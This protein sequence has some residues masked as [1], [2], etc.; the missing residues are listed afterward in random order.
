MNLTVSMISM[1]EEKAVGKVIDS[2]QAVVPEAEVL[3]VDSSSDATPQIAESKGARVVRQFPPQGYGPAMERAL[4]DAGGDV[5]VTLDCD[6]TYPVEMIP[7]LANLVIEDEY[8]IV[9]ATRLARRPQTM[10]FL[11]YLANWTFAK[12]ASVVYGVGTSD[13]HSGM[14]AYRASMIEALEFVTDAS[15]LPVELW[16]KPIA[17]GF[18]AA[19]VPIE[20]SERMGDTTLDRFNSTVWTFKRIFSRGRWSRETDVRG[21][22]PRPSVGH[23][24]A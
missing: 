19:E 8:D 2:I 14:R 1:N 21:P 22:L 7:K 16:L 10:P 23:I 24:D 9:N 4:R 11:N 5:I 20:Y 18:R 13:V 15:A 12:T 3:L 17:L 6:D